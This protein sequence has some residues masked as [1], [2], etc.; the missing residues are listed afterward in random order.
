MDATELREVKASKSEKRISHEG[1]ISNGDTLD[2][3]PVDDKEPLNSEYVI[4]SF[5]E[6]PFKPL[7]D[8]PE[9]N[10]WVLT[11]RALT[12][13]MLAGA[14][15]NASNLYLGLKSDGYWKRV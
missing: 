12:I 7:E 2:Q 10:E 15:V 5:A 3:Y 13:G 14:L 6:D 8:L 11:G 4:D 9:E 1:E